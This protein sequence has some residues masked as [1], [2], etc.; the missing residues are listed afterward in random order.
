[1]NSFNVISAASLSEHLLNFGRH[2]EHCGEIGGA[3]DHLP[4]HER[5][6]HWMEPRRSRW[7]DESKFDNSRALHRRD[8]GTRLACAGPL[9][10]VDAIRVVGDYVTSELEGTR[11]LDVGCGSGYLSSWYAA[12]RPAARVFGIDLCASKIMLAKRFAAENQI[13]N[14]HYAVCDARHFVPDKPFDTII[15]TQGMVGPEI[16]PDDIRRVLS[17]LKPAG[18]FIC[19][20]ALET[21]NQFV[22]FLDNLESAMCLISSLKWLAFSVG[23]G[24]GVYPA[25]I[26]APDASE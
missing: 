13:H 11:I 1:M 21:L 2:F 10:K 17:W 12:C 8:V 7:A 24:R 15:D 19:V 9:D 25:M 20:P 6:K 3:A 4:E 14:I 23:N 22:A 16:G 26:I 18:K 5:L